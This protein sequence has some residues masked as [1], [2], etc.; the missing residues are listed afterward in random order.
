M[1]HAKGQLG[2]PLSLNTVVT[3][4]AKRQN[5]KKEGFISTQPEGCCCLKDAV[6]NS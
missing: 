3:K 5:L 2:S 1:V 6:A 4:M